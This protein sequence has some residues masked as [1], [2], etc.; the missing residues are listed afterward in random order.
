LH[1]PARTWLGLLSNVHL[2][3]RLRDFPFTP[4]VPPPTTTPA[5]DSTYPDVLQTVHTNA[6]VTRISTCPFKIVARIPVV[7]RPLQIRYHP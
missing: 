5:C 4:F 2:P 1:L 6:Q 7:S 3:Q